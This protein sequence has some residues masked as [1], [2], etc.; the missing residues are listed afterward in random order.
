MKRWI[1][2]MLALLLVPCAALCEGEVVLQDEDGNVVSGEVVEGRSLQY[3][4]EGDD[5]LELQQRLLLIHDFIS[6]LI[7]RYHPD[8]MSVEE[9]FF[10]TNVSTAIMV[11]HGRG[12]ILL[13]GARAGIP[14]FEYTPMQIKQSVVG[15]GKADK[16]QVQQM[17]KMLLG[18]REVPKPDDTADAIA[19]AIC[20]AHASGSRLP[21]I[22]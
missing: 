22:M 15:Y 12:A 5:V 1:I 7:T 10:N 20:H 19:V 17:V 3:G 13:A 11:S 8:V 16:H 18:L 21:Y 9:L 14:I 2:L 6:D 4:D